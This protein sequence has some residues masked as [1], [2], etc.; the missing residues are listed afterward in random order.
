MNIKTVVFDLV[1]VQSSAP[2]P[3]EENKTIEPK[4]KTIRKT[5]EEWKFDSKYLER[6]N[7][8]ECLIACAPIANLSVGT[9]LS[10]GDSVPSIIVGDGNNIRAELRRQVCAKISGYKSQDMKK[11]IYDDAKFVRFDDVVDL[12]AERKMSCFYCKKQALLFYEYSRDCDQWT[13]ERIDNAR[14]HNVDNVE[15]ACLNCNLRR[16]T[17]YHE[18]YVFTKQMGTVRLLE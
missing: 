10:I 17:M 2:S 7:Q 4:E 15:I 14:G 16:R 3:F 12:M 8:L 13:L 9:P 5:M 11:G 1:K 6:E 18:R